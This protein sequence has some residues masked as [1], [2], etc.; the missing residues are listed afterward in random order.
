[1]YAA[2]FG[3]NVLGEAGLFQDQSLNDILSASFSVSSPCGTLITSI[4]VF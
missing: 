1:M 2:F 3:G 4:L